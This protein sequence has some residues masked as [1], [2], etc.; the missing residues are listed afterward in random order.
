MMALENQI[1]VVTGASSGMGRE[2][3]RQICLHDCSLDEI[4]LIGRSEKKLKQI[5][6][7]LEEAVI[8]ADT[9]V[10]I[11]PTDLTDKE[12]QNAFFHHL[13]EEKPRIRMLVCAAGMGV[14]GNAE[15]LP[16]KPQLETVELNCEALT[17]VTFGC[18]P[19]CRQGSRILLLSSASAFLPQP[20]FAVYAASKSYVL[21]LARALGRELRNRGISVT[22]VCPGPVD[23]PF[24]KRA[25]EYQKRRPGKDAFLADPKK[26]VKKA[27]RDAMHRRPVS[28]YGFSMKGACLAGKILPADLLMWAFEK[29]F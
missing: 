16:M 4:W 15:R 23:T 13:N 12:D 21:S 10:R 3:A 28:I 26:V 25:E 20:G 14:I 27:L 1:A 2:F 29:L 18:L 6:I 24:F 9:R 11:F 19:C 7:A 8:S 17:A 5:K 22:A